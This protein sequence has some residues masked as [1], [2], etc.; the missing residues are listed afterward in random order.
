V[1]QELPGFSALHLSRMLWS[2]EVLKLQLPEGLGWRLVQR[3]KRMVAHSGEV[4]HLGRL[5]QVE[6]SFLLVEVCSF[7]CLL[8]L[9]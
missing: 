3:V 1:G 4:K 7:S 5:W 9:Q 6:N 8:C 2:S